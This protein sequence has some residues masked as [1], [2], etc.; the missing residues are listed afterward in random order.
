MTLLELAYDF[1][2]TLYIRRPIINFSF[3]VSAVT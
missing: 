2:F 1:M 3:P